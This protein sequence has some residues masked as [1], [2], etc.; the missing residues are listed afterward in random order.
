M[1][2][3]SGQRQ[4]AVPPERLFA[5]LSD[6]QK[7]ISTLP[8]VKKVKSVSAEKAEIVVAPGLAFVKGELETVIEKTSQTPPS[9]AAISIQ[10]KGIGSSSKVAASFHLEPQETGT[11]LRWQADVLELGGLL[12]LAP[13]GLLQGAGQKVIEGW[14][15]Q[16]AQRLQTA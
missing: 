10:S 14:L 2:Q 5:E 13:K 16:L 11:L 15:D 4:F 3:I 12:K 8:D 1:I 7:V 6:M 9:A